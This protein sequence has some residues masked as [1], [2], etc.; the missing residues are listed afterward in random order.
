MHPLDFHRNDRRCACTDSLSRLRGT[1]NAA[2]RESYHNCRIT[3]WERIIIILTLLLQAI[4]QLSSGALKI[5]AGV[6]NTIGL[7]VIFILES[8]PRP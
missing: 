2:S 8:Q 4:Q 5:I 1:V 6:V 3:K 7:V